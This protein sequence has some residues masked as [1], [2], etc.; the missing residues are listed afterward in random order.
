M[1]QRLVISIFY[2]IFIVV[3]TDPT[4]LLHPERSL[5]RNN[6]TFVSSKRWMQQFF[7]STE[8]LPSL[9]EPRRRTH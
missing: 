2:G 3:A 6:R 8:V 9:K 4:I 1:V 5:P 7:L